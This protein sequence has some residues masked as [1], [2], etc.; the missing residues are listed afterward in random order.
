MTELKGSPT[1][2]YHF[3]SEKPIVGQTFRFTNSMICKSFCM[4]IA[5]PYSLTHHPTNR[6]INF[7]IFSVDNRKIY[8]IFRSIIWII[9]EAEVNIET[10][11]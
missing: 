3:R 7:I 6:Q 5:M 10:S 2:I 8:S 11:V 4:A 9:R 1:L